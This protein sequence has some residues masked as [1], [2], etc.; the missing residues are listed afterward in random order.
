MDRRTE[1]RTKGPTLIIE[2][3][4]Y[5]ITVKSYYSCIIFIPNIR[6]LSLITA[7]N[8]SSSIESKSQ[9]EGQ[10]RDGED[11]EVNYTGTQRFFRCYLLGT[12]SWL[13]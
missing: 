4:R 5:A 3:L 1:K 6:H 13:L 9:T 10:I 7:R 8:I 11:M 2:K 12:S